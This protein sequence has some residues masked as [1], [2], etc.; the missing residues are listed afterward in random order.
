M[1]FVK[2]DIL[3]CT[4]GFCL[5]FHAACKAVLPHRHNLSFSACFTPMPRLIPASSSLPLQIALY[6]NVILA[7]IFFLYQCS[8][9]IHKVCCCWDAGWP[10]DPFSNAVHAALHV[11]VRSLHGNHSSYLSWSVR[12]LRSCSPVPGM[13]GKPD[14]TGAF[15]YHFFARKS[16][17]ATARVPSC[18]T[19]QTFVLLPDPKFISVPAVDNISHRAARAVLVFLSTAVVAHR[20]RHWHPI[21]ICF[22]K[23]SRR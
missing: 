21:H 16:C 13:V 4:I 18:T 19:L 23:L 2:N 9:H 17:V 20:A 12:H 15:V 11:P 5:S 6:L 14:G 22:S 7:C 1:I 10:L 8:V 3:V